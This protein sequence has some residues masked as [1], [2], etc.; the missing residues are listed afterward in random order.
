[1]SLELVTP[2]AVRPIDLAEA[3]SHLAVT[4]GDDDVYILSLI[5]AASAWVESYTRQALLL[6]T[7]KQRFQYWPACG[8]IEL[9]RPPLVSVTSVV[10]IDDAGATQTLAS[11]QYA[12]D[13]YSKP[14]RILRAYGVTW[15]TIRREGV[16]API[17]VTFTAGR[18]T[19]AAIP[20]PFKHAIKLM[21]GHWYENREEVNVGGSVTPMP[22]AAR[23]LLDS[24]SHGSYP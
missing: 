2:A 7:W 24:V 16:A 5:D 9:Y 18:A 14:G 17:T 22:S 12:V 3:K 20:A 1:M 13:L 10:Y 8:V 11:N 15:P 23:L 19:P 6:S 4:V 21:V